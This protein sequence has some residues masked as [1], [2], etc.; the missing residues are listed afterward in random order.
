MSKNKRKLV[1]VICCGIIMAGTISTVSAL[2]R[3]ET[4]KVQGGYITFYAEGTKGEK[5]W[6]RTYSGRLDSYVDAKSAGVNELSYN[7]SFFEIAVVAQ[8][9]RL[10]Y[11]YVRHYLGKTGLIIVK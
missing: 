1:S 3:Q 7:E 2:K 9:Y 6:H 11:N 4:Q 5:G 10:D 8:L